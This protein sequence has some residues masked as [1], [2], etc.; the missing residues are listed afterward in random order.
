ME[1]DRG[2]YD[3]SRTLA[4]LSDVHGNLA[5]LQ[6]VL[7]TLEAESLTEVI[8]CGDLVGYGPH[9]VQC[10]ERLEEYHTWSVLGNHDAVAIGRADDAQ[11]DGDGRMAIRWTRRQ[12]SAEARDYLASLPETSQP[13]DMIGMVH[14]S[15]AD[16]LWGRIL[17]RRDA[18]LSFRLD[19][20]APSIRLF[21][22]THLPGL[23]SFA[24][25]AVRRESTADGHVILDS[26]KRYL[27]NPGSVGQPRDGDWRA[28]FC[29]LELGDPIRVRFRRV[30]YDVEATRGAILDAGLPQA[31]GNR[32]LSGS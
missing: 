16:P 18:Y 30:E 6:A 24:G 9:P 13:D 1:P 21:G 10:I 7:A 23:F 19:G 12:L 29:L 31:L 4:V 17:R 27:L 15:M 25:N 8:C 2:R 11:L 26:A 5:A 28:S 32:L 3:P 22:H 14:G 20:D